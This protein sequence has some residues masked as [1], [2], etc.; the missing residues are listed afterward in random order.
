MDARAVLRLRLP[1]ALRRYRPRFDAYTAQERRTCP[2]LGLRPSELR[3]SLLGSVEQR[4]RDPSMT[5]RVHN[6]HVL[7]NHVTG[8]DEHEQ[9][10]LGRYPGRV[11]MVLHV[12]VGTGYPTFRQVVV[13]LPKDDLAHRP[14]SLS[15]SVR[16]SAHRYP[17]SGGGPRPTN[18]G[19]CACVAYHVHRLR[20]AH[21]LSPQEGEQKVTP[22]TPTAQQPT[23]LHGHR[24]GAA[25][26]VPADWPGM[27]T[28]RAL[29][30]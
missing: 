12:P 27:S 17:H 5:F 13:D 16:S 30:S 20:Q 10:A 4:R 8:C 29:S 21:Y 24:P 22:H 23:G 18:E 1:T 9:Y 14:P 3:P 2:V 15:A 7:G 6:V 26:C 11:V 28:R 19:H 25:T